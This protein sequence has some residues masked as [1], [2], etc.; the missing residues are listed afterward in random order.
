[1]APEEAAKYSSSFLHGAKNL[2]L[3]V[4]CAQTRALIACTTI[5]YAYLNAQVCLWLNI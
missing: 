1:M 5:R 2:K 4:S 3:S